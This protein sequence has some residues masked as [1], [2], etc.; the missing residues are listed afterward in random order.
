MRH[1][2]ASFLLTCLASAVL[3]A[4]S[5]GPATAQECEDAEAEAFVENAG[6]R[7]KLFNNG[8]LF[9]SGGDHTYEVPRGLGTQAIFAAGL[10]IG[11]TVEGETRFAGS[12]YGPYEY[13]PGPLGPDG[14]APTPASCAAYD[15]IWRVTL[16]DIARYNE[17]GVATADLAEWPAE[18]GAPVV[19]GDDIADNYDL[20]AGDRPAILGDE[21]AWWVMNDRGGSHDWS[22]TPSIGLEVRATVSTVSDAYAVRRLR[23]GSGLARALH[24]A[25]FYRY[26]L[27]YH[28]DAPWEN[29]YFGGWMDPDLGF[30]SDDYVGS[31][32]P[33]DLAYVYNGDGFDEGSRGYGASPPAAGFAM[34]SGPAERPLSGFMYY[35][36]S[37]VSGDPSNGQE[38]YQFLQG[39][40]RDASPVTFGGTG[41]QTGDRTLYMYPNLP[42]SFWSEANIDGRGTSNTPADRKLIASH[43]PFTMQPGETTEIV[44]AIVYSRSE[45][46]NFASARQL[47]TL[48]APRVASIARALS[49]DPA[50]ATIQLGE[51]PVPLPPEAEPTEAPNRYALAE[52]IW[53]N[54]TTGD[55][56]LRLDLP[57][58]ARV[59]LEVF[60]T[61][62]RR[63][64][65]PVDERLNGAEHRLPVPAGTLAPGPYLYRVTVIPE[66]QGA[67]RSTGRFLIAR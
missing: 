62:G 10:W 30:F 27:T 40:W 57:S 63:V 54:P 5:A 42:P 12:D 64:A 46:G 50:L 3:A 21:T 37:G 51:L 45:A 61:L 7:A 9:W 29:A 13:W 39:L 26:E 48:D 34:V 23:L 44:F 16:E 17:T 18:V 53:P 66:G 41:F 14:D 60:D 43:G 59:L 32:P 15:R 25:T 67:I 49:P 65:T 22:R 38:A 35:D 55:A 6:V 52:T 31:Y 8:A 11:G 58:L 4:L 19:D 24:T 1:R 56:V 47:A 2:Y 36:G 28:G 20:A 33:S